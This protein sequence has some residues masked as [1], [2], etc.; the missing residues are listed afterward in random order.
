[1]TPSNR[2]TWRQVAVAAI[3]IVA[4][5]AMAIV[6]GTTVFVYSHIRTESVAADTAEER[7]AAARARF[8]TSQAFLRVDGA[9]GPVV[10]GRAGDSR[11][12][13]ATLRA[14]A[15]DPTA[16]RLVDISIPFWLLRLVPNGR[17]SLDAST[18]IDFSAER[19]N[20]NLEA[21]EGIGPGLVLDHSEPGGT[22]LLVWTE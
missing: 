16:R 17:I 3:A 6:G 12:A 19:V 13:L 7:I 11:A 5:A 1:M 18:G 2:R 22:K 14:I 21:L 4:V 9:G 8:G 20:V 10:S 15:Y